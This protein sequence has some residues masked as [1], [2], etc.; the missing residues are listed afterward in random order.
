MPHFTTFDGLK[1]HYWDESEGQPV[2]CLPGLTRTGNDFNEMAPH[3]SDVRLIRLDSR[4]RGDS[5]W[6]PNPMNYAVPV[7]AKDALALLDHLG[8]DKVTAFGTSRG[9]M[10]SMMIAAMAKPRLAGVLL[11]DVGPE[12]DRADLQ[13]IVDGLGRNPPYKTYE[14]AAAKY[15]TDWPGFPNVPPERWMVEVR[16]LWKE[17]PE[18]LAVRYDPALRVSSEAVMAGPPVDLWPLFDALAGL[19]LALL[20]GANSRLL[21]PETVAK[22]QARRPDMI[23]AEVPDRAHIPFLDEPESLGVIRALLERTK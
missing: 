19:P 8:V 4:G 1:L 14:E 11:N 10:V 16:R 2:L 17:V 18:G 6:D 7:E 15:P 20:R 5:D 13:A 21:T 12:L 9:G 23:F 22:M 3:L